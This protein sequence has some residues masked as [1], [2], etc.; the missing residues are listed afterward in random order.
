MTLTGLTIRREFFTERPAAAAAQTSTVRE[1]KSYA[2][3]GQRLG[4]ANA[5]VTIVE[6]SDFQC[7]ACRAAAETLR[8]VRQRYPQQ[9]AVLYRHA[10]I[11][12]HEH[13]ADAARASQ[14]AARQGRFEAYHDVLFANQKS[15][16]QLSWAAFADSASVADGD[17]F[18]SCMSST[19]P[20]SEV[21][22]DRSAAQRLGVN[23]T[24]TFLVNNQ[25]VVGAP[26][27]EELVAMI[28]KTL[29]GASRAR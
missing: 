28:E 19:A 15:I 7:P 11:P 9:V 24:P 16:G 4:P 18:D 8:R 5:T 22:N 17:A 3:S 23:A 25:L 2:E 1:W 14:C 13:A 29:R 27:E 10:P 12:S 26:S 21:E 6:F 20:K